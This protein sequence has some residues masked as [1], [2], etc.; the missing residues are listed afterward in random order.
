M[1]SAFGI[2][3]GEFSKAFGPPKGLS[4]FNPISDTK[5]LS[6]IGG[7]DGKYATPEQADAYGRLNQ[8]RNAAKAAMTKKPGPRKP[9][10]HNYR[11]PGF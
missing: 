3:H 2:E 7:G 10:S 5:R 11:R 1:Q 8:Q 9:T 6:R 4:K